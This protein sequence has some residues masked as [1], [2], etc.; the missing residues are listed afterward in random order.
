[1]DRCMQ[2]RQEV[3]QI[4]FNICPLCRAVYEVTGWRGPDDQVAIITSAVAAMFNVLL[5]QLKKE[6]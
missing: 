3:E 5:D 4:E 6:D 1:M 2:C